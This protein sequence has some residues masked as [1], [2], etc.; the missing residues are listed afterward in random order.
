MRHGRRVKKLGR[1]AAHR[2]A[3]LANMAT[4]LIL[5]STIKTT[6]VK[7]R[8]VRRVVDR[9]VTLAK[10][11]DLHA[12]RQAATTVRD[13]A[14][15]KRLFDEIGPQLGSRSGGYTRAL[16]L[17]TRRGDGAP[18]SVVQ[19]LVPKPKPEKQTKGKKKKDRAGSSTPAAKKEKTARKKSSAEG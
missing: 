12:R 17:G 5:H 16:H 1:T 11:G 2:E 4:S 18:L 9:L 13:K 14:A 3:M 8:A 6:P 7:A 19:L 10:R 15:L